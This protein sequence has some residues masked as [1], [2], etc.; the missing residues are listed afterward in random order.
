MS[1]HSFNVVMVSNQLNIKPIL[2][3]TA[4]TAIYPHF[5]QAIF[6]LVY[7]PLALSRVGICDITLKISFIYYNFHNDHVT[8]MTEH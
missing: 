2:Y 6:Q 5:A 7:L 8:N 4:E 3:K 1:T